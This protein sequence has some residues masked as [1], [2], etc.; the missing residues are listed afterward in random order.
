MVIGL[1][2]IFC[3]RLQ[4]E[5]DHYA[6]L[7][8]DRSCTAAQIRGAYRLLAKRHHPDVNP[9]SPSADERTREL[10]AAYEVLIDPARRRAYDS[11][12]G[13]GKASAPIR[14]G[15]I[16]RNIAQDVRL[17]LE[18]FLRGTS[19]EVRV[20][21]PANPDGPET[22]P[23]HIPP[24]TAPNARF[25]LPR[26]GVFAGGFVN[27]R[28]RPMPGFRFKVRGSDLRCDLRISSSRAAA[29]GTEMI[30]SPAGAPLR[31]QIPSGVGRGEIIRI[32]GEGM[33]KPR[34]GR[35]DLLVRITYRPEVRVSRVS[36]Q[37]SH[38]P[39]RRRLT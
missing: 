30:A 32:V 22:Y 17:R 12:T 29:G 19:L 26:T 8:L 35:G 27:V 36:A 1:R 21:D 23:L 2:H 18:D 16:E 20:N 25:R 5:P 9:D 15:K 7:G 10:N 3:K 24:G 4:L 28:L 38:A 13:N 11:E 39:Q 33:P 37:T 31:V 14:G 6:T 34:G